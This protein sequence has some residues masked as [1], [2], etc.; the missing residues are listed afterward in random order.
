MN[1]FDAKTARSNLRVD[2]CSKIPRT[3]N[4]TSKKIKKM[5]DAAEALLNKG[6]E[7]SKVDELLRRGS[8]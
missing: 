5:V 7:R 8:I 6:M 1:A 2:L 4:L 3:E